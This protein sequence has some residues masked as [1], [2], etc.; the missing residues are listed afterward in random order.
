VDK[1]TGVLTQ[2]E[3]DAAKMERALESVCEHVLD[4]RNGR[5]PVSPAPS[6]GCPSYCHAYD[7]CRVSPQRREGKR[8]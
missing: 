5:F 8:Q 4:A 2:N 7:I 1:K 6:C 3:A